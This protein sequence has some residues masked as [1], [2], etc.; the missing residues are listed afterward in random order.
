MADNRAIGINNTIPWHISQD[1]KY[2]K[3]TTMGCPMIMGRKTF[4]SL[5][6][7][8]P[9]RPHIIVTR[10]K[11]EEHNNPDK[12][13]YYSS[14]IEHALEVAKDISKKDQK[15]EIFI[16]GG[17]QI[18]KQSLEQNLIDRL[19]ITEVHANYDGDTFFTEFDKNIWQEK[20]RQRH[21]GNPDFS[22]VIY[23]KNSY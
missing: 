15:D 17:A 23:D 7:I 19:Y 13:L 20:S 14:S 8:L 2:F 10:S 9:G 6:G 4:E 3:T 5:P 21:S 12:N 18:Y 1:F 11:D 22:F 16:I